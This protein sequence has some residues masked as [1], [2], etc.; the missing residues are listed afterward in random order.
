MN[1]IKKFDKN[2]LDKKVAEHM[3][4]KKYLNAMTPSE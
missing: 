3:V 1:L 2:A 4:S